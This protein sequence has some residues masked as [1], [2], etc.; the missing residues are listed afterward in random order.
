MSI[1]ISYVSFY[2]A[3]NGFS[4]CKKQTQSCSLTTF[5]QKKN[6]QGGPP[7]QPTPNPPITQS[8]PQFMP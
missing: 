6:R 3:K 8:P 1:D 7:P 2:L 5:Q 4:T